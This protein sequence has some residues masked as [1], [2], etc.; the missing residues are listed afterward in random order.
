MEKLIY[1]E[2]LVLKE[3]SNLYIVNLTTY[4]NDRQI[5]EILV[6]PSNNKVEEFESNFIKYD[7]AEDF[8]KKKWT[9]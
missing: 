4:G 6:T 3:N 1:K 2:E 8:F 7:N 5:G 9:K